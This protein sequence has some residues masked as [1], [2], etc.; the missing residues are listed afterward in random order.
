MHLG[1]LSMSGA[2]LLVL[3]AC[4]V[5]ARGRITHGD[6]GL[7]NDEN[8]AALTRVL[9]FCRR[10]GSAKLGLQIAHAGRKASAQVPWE[11]GRGL[12]DGQAPWETIS[13]SALPFADEWH[14]P[15]AATTQDL[16]DL[17]AAFAA[18]TARAVRLGFDL[19]ELHGAHG[20]LIH[21]FLSPLSNRRTDEYGGSLENR[22]RFPLRVF[23]A[24]KA[25]C[26]D[27]TAIGARITGTD[28]MDGGITIDDA[29]AFASELKARGCHY[30]DVS[31]AGKFAEDQDRD[32]TPATRRA[33]RPRSAAAPASRCGASGSSS[34]RNR[35][36]RSWRPGN[37]T[38]WR[39]AGPRSTIRTGPGTPRRCSAAR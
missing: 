18:T 28:W 21:Q 30:V 31:S 36:R 22:M 7:Y 34:R 24:M 39:S 27:T 11:G 26:G 25:A 4:A 1:S 14:T 17:V 29:V 12:A 15:R 13:A 6:V 23:D 9:K 3:E 33:S 2:S 35:P 20:Y 32:R 10:Y 16:D 5:E 8:E 19:V 37:P 38:W